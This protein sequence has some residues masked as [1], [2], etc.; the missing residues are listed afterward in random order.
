MVLILQDR[1]A[2][3]LILVRH[4]I[5]IVVVEAMLFV[6]HPESDGDRDSKALRLVQLRPQVIGAPRAKGVAAG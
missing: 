5:R 6:A 4:L 1:L 3:A 2:G